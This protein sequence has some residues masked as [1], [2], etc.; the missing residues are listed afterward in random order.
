MKRLTAWLATGAALLAAPP[1][2]AQDPSAGRPATYV[3]VHGAW[4]G[5]WDWKQVAALLGARGHR[6][7]RVALTGLGERVHLASPQIGLDT[8][9]TDVVNTILWDDLRDVV[10]VGHSYGGVVITGAADRVRDRIRHLVYLDAFVP[11]NGESVM[12]LVRPEMA[13]LAREGERTGFIV[14]PWVKPDAPLPKDVPQPLKTFTDKVAL[15][16]EATRLPGTYILTVEA[17]KTEDPFDR[18]AERARQLGWAVKKMT[19]DHVPERSAPEALVELLA[20]AA[21]PNPPGEAR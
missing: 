21:P 16:G 8:H 20:S 14:P 12:D 18:F 4:G 19:A 15:T 11:R 6:V 10:L 5:S 9:V 3:I 1:A 17:G 2:R 13:A 7:T